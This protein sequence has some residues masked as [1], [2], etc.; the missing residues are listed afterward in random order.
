MEFSW[1]E[2][3]SRLPFLSPGIFKIQG[4][5]LHLL[6]LQHWQVGYLPLQHLGSHN[7]FLFIYLLFSHSVTPDFSV[8]PWNAAHQASQSIT[9]SWSLLKLM[10]IKLVIPSNH[11]IFCCARLL[12]PSVLPSIKVFCS[13]SALSTR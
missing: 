7:E 8:T 3:W 12:L 1:Q 10:S 9:N 13:E 11:L 2:Y 4:S 5:N 6:H